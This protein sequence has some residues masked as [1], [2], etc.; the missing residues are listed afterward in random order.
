MRAVMC[1]AHNSE[2][3][4]ARVASIPRLSDLTGLL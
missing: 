1:T 4:P 3:A 2:P